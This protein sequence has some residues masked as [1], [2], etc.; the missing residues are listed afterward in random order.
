MRVRWR[1]GANFSSQFRKHLWAAGSGLVPSFRARVFGPCD[2]VLRPQLRRRKAFDRICAGGK[3]AAR[4][5]KQ[6]GSWQCRKASRMRVRW[7][8]GAS[9]SSQFRKQLL[10]LW[11]AGWP[12]ASLSSQVRKQRLALRAASS[13]GPRCLTPATGSFD[14]SCAGGK[15]AARPSK[16]VGSWQCRKAR[17]MRVRLRLEGVFL[18]GSE[19]NLW[20]YVLLA[21][22]SFCLSGPGC[23]ARQGPSTAA[24]PE[25]SQLH[26][27]WRL[28]VQEGQQNEGS[29]RAWS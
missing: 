10:A 28:A 3:P 12:A 7:R 22:G 1:P 16:Q 17:R 8:P 29:M 18:V 21:P 19:S 11:A 15:P 25:E 5:S 9:F 23:L 20:Q 24:V 13:S 6:V 4:Q 2:R 14:C 27:S 26:A